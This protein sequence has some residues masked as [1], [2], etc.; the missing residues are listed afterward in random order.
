MPAKK[1]GS[2]PAPTSPGEITLN[3]DQAKLLSEV[4]D[5]LKPND[6]LTQS[7]WSAIAMKIGATTAKAAYASFQ[8][9]YKALLTMI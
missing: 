7:D 5:R 3:H 1:T 9:D 4:F 8:I 6:V 2:V